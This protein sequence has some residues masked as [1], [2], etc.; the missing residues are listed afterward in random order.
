MRRFVVGCGGNVAMIYA[1]ALVPLM[2]ATGGAIDY[3]RAV[4][5]KTSMGAALDAAAL[6]VAQSKN[7]T[8]AQMQTLAQQY[9]DANYHQSSDYGTPVAVTVATSGQTITVSTSCDVPTTVLHA[10]GFTTWPVAATSTVTYGQTKLWVSLVLDN[11]GSMVQTD[12]TGLS[13]ISALKSASHSLLSMLQSATSTDGDVQVAIIPFARDVYLGTGYASSSW[14]SFTDFQAEPPS[15]P[16]T[17]YGPNSSC[18]WSDSVNYY[19]CQANSTN[20]SAQITKIQSNGLICPSLNTYTRHYYNGCYNSVYNSKTKTYSHTWT[21]NATSTWTGCVTDRGSSTA[22]TSST[23]YDVTVTTPTASTTNSMMVAENG[24]QACP[25]STVMGLSYDWTALNSAID[26]MVAN[27]ST[28]QTIG[29]VWGWHAMTQ[30]A[31][32]SAP[33]LPDNTQRI[34][35]LLS[36]GLNTQ[37][38]WSGNGSNTSS[39]VDARMAYACANAKAAGVIIYT[40]FVDL[41]GTQGSSTVLQSCATDSSKYYDLTS[42]SQIQ[43]A[44]NDIAQQITNLRVTQ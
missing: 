18:P 17:S 33:T 42:S 19:H 11:T 24:N 20:G 29:L 12:S 27:G 41:N 14:L 5:V 35:I 9:F 32:L 43:S 37:N 8:T 15:K 36:D 44:F 4:V 38:R 3:A 21:A 7:L 26:S 1:L 6:A 31:P 16:G 39:A 13:K 34:I 22:P 30:G 10:L 28:N 2:L 23:D 40:V 25:G